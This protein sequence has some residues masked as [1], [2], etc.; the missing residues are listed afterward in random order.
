YTTTTI[1]G[2][3][4]VPEWEEDY[5]RYGAGSNSHYVWT[6]PNLEK[7]GVAYTGAH[8]AAKNWGASTS[9]GDAKKTAAGT[10]TQSGITYAIQN[11]IANANLQSG[12]IR[13]PYV[14]LLSDGAAIT[15]SSNWNETPANPGVSTTYKKTSGGVAGFLDIAASSITDGSQQVAATTILAAAYQKELLTTAYANNSDNAETQFYSVG[16]GADTAINGSTTNAWCAL[17]PKALVTEYD[18]GTANKN[19]PD[20]TISVNV[21]KELWSRQDDKKQSGYFNGNSDGVIAASNNPGKFVYTTYYKYASTYPDLGEAFEKLSSDVKSATES[22]EL[23]VESNDSGSG[24][25]GSDT[26]TGAIEFTDVIGAGMKVGVPKMGSVTGT[27]DSNN[28]ETNKKYT[29][30]NLDSVVTIKTV[31]GVTT[32]TWNIAAKDM[33]NHM[34]KIDDATANPKTYTTASPIKLSYTVDLDSSIVPT[35]TVDT[36]YYTNAFSTNNGTK[37]ANTVARFI[38]TGDNPYYYYTS[39]K[40]G[41]VEADAADLDYQSGTFAQYVLGAEIEPISSGIAGTIY[42]VY[43]S[44]DMVTASG[45]PYTSVDI[46]KV[47]DVELEGTESSAFMTALEASICNCYPCESDGDLTGEE[48]IKYAYRTGV[49]LT[50]DDVKIGTVNKKEL[51]HRTTTAAYIITEALSNGMITASLGNNGRIDLI[52]GIVLTGTSETT[53]GGTITYTSNVYNYTGSNLTDMNISSVI[54]SN[55]TDLAAVTSGGVV[56]TTTVSND[57][58]T[59]TGVTLAPGSNEFKYTAKTPPTASVDTK[60]KNI[61][62]ADKMMSGSKVI[63]IKS[64]EVTT[65]IIAGT[66]VTININKDDSPWTTDAPTITLVEEDDATGTERSLTGLPDGTYYIYADGVNTGK[67]ITVD[68][69]ASGS[70]A[71]EETLNYYTLTVTS[72]DAG[73]TTPSVSGNDV[74]SGNAGSWNTTTGSGVYLAGSRVDI[75][76]LLEA[77]YSFED[78]SADNSS[79]NTSDMTRSDSIIMPNY[80]LTLTANTTANDNTAYKVYHY[81]MDTNGN[82]VLVD[83]DNL[84]GDT[85][86][87]LTL[88]NLKDGQLLVPGGITYK[89]GKVDGNVV[90]KATI[91]G[92]GSLEIYLYYDRA[93]YTLTVTEGA[94]TT[95][96]G[97]DSGTYYYGEEISLEALA[98][99]GYV[100]DGWEGTYTDDQNNISFTMPAGD[101]TISSTAKHVPVNHNPIN[102]PSKDDPVDLTGNTNFGFRGKFANLSGLTINGKDLDMT[103]SSDGTIYYITE[104]GDDTIIG[105]VT[106]DGDDAVQITIYEEYKKSLPDG[107]YLLEAVFDDNGVVTSGELEFLIK[108]ENNNNNTSNQDKQTPVVVTENKKSPQTGD[109]NSLLFWAGIGMTA[110]IGIWMSMRVMKKAV[111]E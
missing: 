33:G 80:P 60:Y 67:T 65:T 46:G 87:E 49:A 90:T 2:Q 48:D 3:G 74:S 64:N 24:S 68:H 47:V 44:A 71:N 99:A 51:E 104:P 59:W 10:P 16:L 35:A 29:F 19:N 101:V 83:T 31:N 78:W 63:D 56:S 36:T 4:D 42:Q 103:L 5:L 89:E 7:D 102:P 95:V 81:V 98:D 111:E 105:E 9:M 40:V 11:T 73:S 100:F 25:G 72:G 109:S 28:T 52:A 66:N 34:Y 70:G 15:A 106:P 110:I 21:R 97:N 14:F 22:V 41:K 61:T 23:P 38:P 76:V 13:Q 77:G 20:T 93:K 84:T 96:S 12:E 75:E 18:T 39:A 62:T 85:A 91:E 43:I 108:R 54:D 32:L 50:G 107:N 82:Y 45:S 37:T 27:A 30:E 53:A 6:S 58:V 88:S 86:S 79:F 55:L 69:T 1:E 17:N 57:T 8:T 94:H 92:D 26:I